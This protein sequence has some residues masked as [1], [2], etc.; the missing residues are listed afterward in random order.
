MAGQCPRVAV[1]GPGKPCSEQGQ[2]EN[3]F[4]PL[5]PTL[6]SGGG[7]Q[8]KGGSKSNVFGLSSFH[9]SCRSVI[10]PRGAKVGLQ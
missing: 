9:F 6:R 2:E 8:G 7:M 3:V 10:E 5:D 1:E 4:L